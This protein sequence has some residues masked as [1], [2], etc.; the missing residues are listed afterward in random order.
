MPITVDQIGI[1]EDNI[2]END[3]EAEPGP[4]VD[5]QE[6]EMNEFEDMD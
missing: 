4:D 5:I 6:N 1:G 2:I 3:T